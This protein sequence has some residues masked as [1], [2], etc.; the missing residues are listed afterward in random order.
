MHYDDV[1]KNIAGLIER[2]VNSMLA[3]I[4]AAA[5]S[6]IG[7][8][9]ELEIPKEKS[10]GDISTNIAMKL[11][12]HARRNPLELAGLILEKVKGELSSQEWLETVEKAEVKAPGFINFFLH[13]DHLHKVLLEIKR[14]K[15]NFGKSALGRGLK[16][17]I[18]FVSANPTGPLTIAHG[19]QAAIGDSLANILKFLGY[20]V[21]KEY[22]TND[23]GTQMDMLGSSIRSR[24]LDLCGIKEEFPQD[25]YKGSY[26]F[27]I[28]KD[29]KKRYGNRYAAARDIPPF[30][31]FGL[32][33]ILSDIKKDLKD[34]SVKFDVWY[35]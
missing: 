12:K 31:K 11:S 27:D 7:L 34:F 26:V 4:G 21:T 10:H 30:R 29:F 24:Y 33:W 5:P 8:K 23:E 9:A 2:S 6:S 35:S 14:K 15:D 22:Y 20:K 1:E 3:D 25:G 16:L 28:A 19:R 17:Q 32:K 13:K 18:E